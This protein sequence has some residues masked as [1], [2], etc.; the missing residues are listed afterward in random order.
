VGQ[1][2]KPKSSQP[3]FVKNGEVKYP[4]RMLSNR[5][6]GENFLMEVMLQVSLRRVLPLIRT[7]ER[8]SSWRS[9]SRSDLGEYV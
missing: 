7:E 6:G 8:S 9:C 5:H 3:K 2:L 1:D 4:N